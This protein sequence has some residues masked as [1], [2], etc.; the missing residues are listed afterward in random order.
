M[1]TVLGLLLLPA[2]L[3]AA[4]PPP[5][6]IRVPGYVGSAPMDLPVRITL[7]PNEKNRWVCLYAVAVRGGGDEVTSCWEVMA[8]KE[9][10]T[11]NRMIRHMSAGVWE[12]VAAVL[13]N[14]E[15]ATLS[16]RLTI[17]VIGIGYQSDPIN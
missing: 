1:R 16:N 3:L 15:Q 2:I 13:R 17:H 14:D 4:E 6:K 10:R 11:T 5:L 9:P 8:E 7:E 12:I